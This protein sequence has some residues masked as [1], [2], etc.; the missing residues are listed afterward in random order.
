M[1]QG[2]PFNRESWKMWSGFYIEKL[3]KLT[4]LRLSSEW[5]DRYK[6]MFWNKKSFK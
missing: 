6:N 4:N 1:G 3:H 2:I 5:I